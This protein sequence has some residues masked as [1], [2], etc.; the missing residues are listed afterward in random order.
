MQPETIRERAARIRLKNKA[1]A[2]ATGLTEMTIGR[3]LSEQT[4]PNITTFNRIEAAIA[5][6]E[7]RLRDYLVRL[8]PIKDEGRVA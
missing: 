4:S 2:E 5:A 1:I 6:E 7:L 3:T 8:H